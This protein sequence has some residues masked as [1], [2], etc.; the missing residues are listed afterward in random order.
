MGHNKML[1]AMQRR[2]FSTLGNN[3]N[4]NNI[5]VINC[6]SSSV[7]FQIIN[8]STPE[9]Q[10]ISGIAERL[11]TP[12]AF[13]KLKVQDNKKQTIPIEN[14]NHKV[15]CD[16][17]Y[18]LIKD[19]DIKAIGHRVVH[20]GKNFKKSVLVT[21]DVKSEIK[22]LFPL[23]PLHN[24]KNL[25]GIELM[26]EK[27]PTLKQI[28]VFDTSFHVNSVPEKTYRYAVPENWY[29]NYN[30]RRY[31]FHGTSH[32]Y[33]AC[34]AAKLLDKPIENLKI[35]TAHLGHGCS[36]AAT[37]NGFSVDTSMGFSPLEGLIMGSRSGDI[38]ANVINYMI[39]NLNCQA[40]DIISDLNNQS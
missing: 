36:V 25:M 11:A 37:K 1:L 39:K 18:E 29:Q 21:D 9:I 23:A 12:K 13:I 24:P 14:S 15:A 31:G 32:K 17:I 27:F 22:Q 20:G 4:N 6:G 38:D 40:N 10:K 26:Q 30:V 16:H 35:I 8:P 5:L 19:Y 28:A 34:E 7:K 33:V 2:I 3:I